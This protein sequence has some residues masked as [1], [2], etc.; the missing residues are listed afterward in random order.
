MSTSGCRKK[1]TNKIHT[2]VIHYGRIGFSTLFRRLT[3]TLI[4]TVRMTNILRPTLYR[5]RGN[6]NIEQYA[7]RNRFPYN[8]LHSPFL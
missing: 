7:E 5:G 4:K 6:Y 2:H 8:R 3:K 1:V